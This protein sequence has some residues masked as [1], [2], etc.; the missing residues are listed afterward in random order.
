MKYY[1][2]KLDYSMDDNQISSTK[3]KIIMNGDNK[4]LGI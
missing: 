1:I 3:S 2:V 4:I